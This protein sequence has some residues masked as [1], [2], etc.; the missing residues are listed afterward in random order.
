MSVPLFVLA[1]VLFAGVGSTRAADETLTG[2]GS[3]LVSP[4]LSVW[5]DDFSAKT[6]TSIAYTPFGS[7]AG[8]LAITQ[9][10]VVSG[11]FGL[12]AEGGDWVAAGV[13]GEDL[14]EVGEER[15]FA[16][17][18]G[19]RGGEESFDACVRLVR[20]GCRVRACGR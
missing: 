19:D 15:L 17:A 6:G 13:G 8:I 10:V 20:I 5:N 2:S 7:S 1:A 16:E 4:L 3:S 12:S 11:P 18:A 9:R 14:G